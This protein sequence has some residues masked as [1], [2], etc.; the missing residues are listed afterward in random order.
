MSKAKISV[1]LQA[2]SLTSDALA[3]LLIR[4][5][6]RGVKVSVIVD[7]NRINE[8]GSDAMKLSGLL[9]VYSDS[10]HKSAHSKI[11]VIDEGTVITGSMN[12]TDSAK[13]N[14]ENVLILKDRN[15]VKSYLENFKT[16][17]E[18]SKRVGASGDRA[19]P[20]RMQKVRGEIHILDFAKALAPGEPDSNT[21]GLSL[22]SQSSIQLFD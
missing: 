17:L 21:V 12:F 22:H 19:I 4:L 11:I 2:Y 6:E 15:L 7:A 10:Q 1:R 3:N 14:A 20:S 8:R 13:R 18:H 5:Q 9:S 16:H